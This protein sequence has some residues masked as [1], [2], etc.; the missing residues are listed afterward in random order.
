M[1][2][3]SRCEIDCLAWLLSL[4]LCGPQCLLHALQVELLVQ[5]AEAGHLSAHALCAEGLHA[6]VELGHEVVVKLG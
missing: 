5:A 6:A 4:L 3:Y 2:N 1:R